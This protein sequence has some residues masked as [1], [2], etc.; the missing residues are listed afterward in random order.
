M[1]KLTNYI[2]GLIL[3]ILIVLV[4]YFDSFKVISTQIQSIL[5]N[6]EQKELLEKF[7]EF[8]SSKKILL[9]VDGLEKESLEK[10]KNIENE[11]LKIDGLKLEKNQSN[12]NLQKF[13]EDYKFYI[14]NFDKRNLENLNINSKLEEIKFNLINADFSYFFDKND[15]LSLL[16]KTENKKNYSLKNGHLIIK[17]LGYLS[18][19]TINSS[20]NSISQYEEIY[21]LVQN[22]TNIYENVKV[23]SPIFYFVENSRII[24]NDVKTIILSSTI[25]LV[26]LYILILRDLKLLI[27]SFITLSSS[28]LLALFISSFIFKELSIFVTVFG[29]SISTVAI[30]YMFH[31]YVHNYYEEKKEF[32]KHVFL[33]MI[34]TVGAFFIISFISFDLIKQI[35]YFSIISL[36]FSYLQFSF[37]YPKIGFIYKNK[38]EINFHLFSKIKPSVVILLSF[39]LIVISLK[40]LGFDSNLKNLDVENKKLNQLENFFNE[41][42]TNQDNIPILI[43]ANS[44]DSLIKNSKILKNEYPNAFVPLSVLI[45]QEEFLEKKEFL[46]KI[47]IDS[48]KSQLEIKSLDFGFKE[49][50][51]NKSYMYN[52]QIPNYTQEDIIN[53]GLEVL[54]FKDYFISYANV[55]KS[56]E[57]EFYNYSFVESLS[58]KSMFEESLNSIYKELIFYGFTTILFI[59]IMVLIS[60]KKNYLN[61]FSYIIFPF[62][63][64]L[65]LSFFS[66]FNILH[67]FM[68]FI[69][70]SISIDYGIYMGSSNINQNS[71]E[72]ILY[73]LL[74]TFAGF[75]VLI[76]SKV[77]ALFSIGITATIGIFA[78]AILLIILKRSK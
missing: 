73:S 14:N 52:V 65:L 45:S 42:L 25:V 57:N 31:H 34:T 63:L 27:N 69:I 32:N 5:P 21:D 37:L 2:N 7:N 59:I 78:I 48:I 20:I 70:L 77:N 15:P 6:S 60:S 35:C 61:T 9:Y 54:A 40:Q 39:V 23:F 50:F 1:F 18:I 71:Y 68:L 62:S 47:K 56:Q 24:K 49:N 43:K 76:F 41:K 46:E 53:L 10:I 13:Q 67:F 55:P 74:S 19:F 11:L 16:E 29:I 38:K 75:G 17:D 36:V 33:G 72:A 51:F 66:S 64:I 22:K 44:I 4:I 28:I 3:A 26:L 8:Q 58:I 30:D 12:K